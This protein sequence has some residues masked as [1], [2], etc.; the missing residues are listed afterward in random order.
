MTD[1]TCDVI[2]QLRKQRKAT[3]TPM[4]MDILSASPYTTYTQ[5]QLN[6]RR[7]AEILQYQPKKQSTQQNGITKS[8]KFAQ[9]VN[10]GSESNNSSTSSTTTC[11]DGIIYTPSTSCGVPGP[12]QNLYLDPSIPLYNYPSERTYNL[13]KTTDDRK[14]NVTY[15]TDVVCDIVNVTE[16]SLASIY[17]RDG[18]DEKDYTFTLSI[19]VNIVLAGTNTSRGYD[20][21]FSRNVVDIALNNATVYV[22][23]NDISL[24]TSGISKQVVPST[25]R[26][27]VS[28]LS[29]NT[30][31][32]ADNTAFS[33]NVFSGELVF[34]NI[35]LY[36]APGYV[37]DFKVSING[38]L[39]VND[40]D[41]I[42]SDYFSPMS[43]AV[44][45]NS[46]SAD[47]SYNCIVSEPYSTTTART[48]SISGT[49]SGMTT[50]SSSTWTVGSTA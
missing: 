47:S 19:P 34:G 28:D 14:W 5:D 4:R 21:D 49:S 35:Q 23:Y 27:N 31:G 1:S 22:Y 8:Q 2:T 29:L 41:Y 3:I 9:I 10:G 38:N 50:T 15:E 24:N 12:V 20:L 6:M 25:D 43:Y 26:S 44:V 30:I 17:I 7:K 39:D 16:S 18:I 48:F 42:E 37:Y 33:A 45:L 36:T 46:T 32:T 11:N 40:P 13:I